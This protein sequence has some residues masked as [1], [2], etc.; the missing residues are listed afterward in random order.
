MAI[1]KFNFASLRNANE[2]AAWIFFAFSSN[3][4]YKIVVLKTYLLIHSCCEHDPDKHDDGN[5]KHGF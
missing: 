5:N 4:A 3:Y 1:G 2:M